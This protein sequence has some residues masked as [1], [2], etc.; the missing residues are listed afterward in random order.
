MAS[1][2][3]NLDHKELNALERELEAMG[4]PPAHPLRCVECGC[5]DEGEH[6]WTLRLDCDGELRAFCPDCDEREFG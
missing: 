6:G 3:D 2:D 4:A 5:E 1:G